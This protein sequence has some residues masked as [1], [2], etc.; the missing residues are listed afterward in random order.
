M[1]R[2]LDCRRARARRPLLHNANE[3]VR[4]VT[5]ISFTPHDASRPL[6]PRKFCG[7]HYECC[8]ARLCNGVRGDIQAVSHNR[9]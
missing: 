7:G 8:V 3:F 6:C 2:D 5:K 4:M 9:C 1:R